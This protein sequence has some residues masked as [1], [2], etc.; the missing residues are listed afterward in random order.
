MLRFL[1]YCPPGNIYFVMAVLCRV[2]TAVGASMGLSYAIIGHYFP[3]K[4]SSLVVN[5]N[6]NFNAFRI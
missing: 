2:V 4:I 3:N 6:K 1:D 5:L